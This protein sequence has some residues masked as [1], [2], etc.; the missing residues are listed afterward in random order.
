[1]V[2]GDLERAYPMC[3]E[4]ERILREVG[5]RWSLC[6][7]L[8]D[9]AFLAIMRDDL[10]L[11]GRYLHEGLI[12]GHT[13]GNLRSVVVAL[14]ATAAVIAGRA[15]EGQGRADRTLAPRLCGA[16]MAHVHLAG[17]FIWPDTKTIY[18]ESVHRV[19][20]FVD[21]ESWKTGYAEGRRIGIDQAVQLAVEALKA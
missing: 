7:A 12:T 9:L 20:S 17:L 3:V 2:E 6:W 8:N 1:V 14:A 11:A 13:L 21:A 10:S 15:R 5:D 4:A 16:S 18:D 19:L